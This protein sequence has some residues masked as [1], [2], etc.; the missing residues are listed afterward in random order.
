MTLWTGADYYIETL[1]KIDSTKQNCRRNVTI[2][3]IFQN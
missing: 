2:N 3:N 1:S